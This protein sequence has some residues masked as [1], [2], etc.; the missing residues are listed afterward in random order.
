M[1]WGHILYD[2]MGLFN[3]RLVPVIEFGQL[4]DEQRRLL[5]LADTKKSSSPI[6]KIVKL[7]ISSKIVKQIERQHHGYYDGWLSKGKLRDLITVL[8]ILEKTLKRKGKSAIVAYQNQEGIIKWNLS[9][10]Q[11]DKILAA[12]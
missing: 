7:Q 1:L 3:I 8:E 6:S 11:M 12:K 4:A 5:F 2:R 10:K 9:E